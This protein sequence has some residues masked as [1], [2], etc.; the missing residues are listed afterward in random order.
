LDVDARRVPAEG[1]DRIDTLLFSES[2]GRFVLTAD[3]ARGA[4]LE[5]LFAGLPLACIGVVTQEAAL[6]VA[7]MDGRIAV[8]LEV[9]DMRA[10]WKKPFGHLI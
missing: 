7:G 9:D 4:E 2:A 1:V 8:S 5:A 6:K 10:S 3:P